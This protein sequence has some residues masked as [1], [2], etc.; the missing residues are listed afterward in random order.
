MDVPRA[1]AAG[2]PALIMH[3]FLIFAFAA[4]EQRYDCTNWRCVAS[5][6]GY[7][8]DL[9]SCWAGCNYHYECGWNGTACQMW[10]AGRQGDS[11]EKCL[12]ACRGVW[13]CEYQYGCVMGYPP[14]GLPM[15]TSCARCAGNCTRPSHCPPS[16]SHDRVGRHW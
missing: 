12:A 8:P 16:D 7:Y 2:L 5:E 9:R 4:A 14:T 15:W 13:Y 6:R 10:P 1:G 11:A 3:A